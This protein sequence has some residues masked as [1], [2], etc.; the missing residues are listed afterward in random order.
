MLHVF[1]NLILA[2]WAVSVLPLC[3]WENWDARKLAPPPAPRACHSKRGIEETLR[4]RSTQCSPSPFFRTP[5]IQ[6]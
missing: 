1:A 5:L 2:Q 4:L 3:R 6:K